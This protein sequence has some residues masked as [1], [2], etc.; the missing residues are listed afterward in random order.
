MQKLGLG[1]ES[2]KKI[3]P[4]I[5][6]ASISG[7]GHKSVYQERP[8]YPIKEVT[9][10]TDFNCQRT[11][12]VQFWLCISFLSLALPRFIILKL[13]RIV[14]LTFGLIKFKTSAGSINREKFIY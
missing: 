14:P 12:L 11:N 8:G 1:Y 6:Y 13:V 10:L 2:L 5:I 7:F 9:K 3:N 4:K